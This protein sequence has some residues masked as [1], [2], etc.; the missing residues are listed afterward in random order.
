VV[1]ILLSALGLLMT[2]VW[3]TA[4][5][6]DSAPSKQVVILGIDGMDPVLLKTY[7]DEGRMPNFSKLMARGG[8]SA[9]E[10]SVVPQSPV[11]W[12]TF[13]TGMDPG[14][15]GSSIFSTGTRRRCCP[16][17]RWRRRLRRQRR[18]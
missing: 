3:A 12:S 6:A 8:F 18:G 1:T 5:S 15:T 10:T 17:S 9:L 7:V 13:I 2:P 16:F 11:A 4:W 14:G